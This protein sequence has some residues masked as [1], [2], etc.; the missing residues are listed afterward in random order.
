M[1]KRSISIQEAERLICLNIKSFIAD[2]CLVDKS[3]LI[4]NIINSN[5]DIL[6]D[7][8]ESSSEMFFKPGTLCYDYNARLLE[9]YNAMPSICIDMR[10]SYKHVLVSFFLHLEDDFAGV[11][12]AKEMFHKNCTLF[13]LSQISNAFYGARIY[14]N[15]HISHYKNDVD[16][17][18]H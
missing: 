8:I 4:E 10:F 18:L 17:F 7:V 12:L 3:F 5:H 9:R 16:P 15:S 13:A 2:L 1:T 14:D 6:N 11:S